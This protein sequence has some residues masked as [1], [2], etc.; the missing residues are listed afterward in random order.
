MHHD[1]HPGGAPFDLPPGELFR[2]VD[3]RIV[4]TVEWLAHRRNPTVRQVEALACLLADAIPSQRS[5]NFELAVDQAVASQSMDHL[6]HLLPQLPSAIR[7]A[8]MNRLELLV[9][10]LRLYGR[11]LRSVLSRGNG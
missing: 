1:S 8:P 4:S 11:I 7:P 6:L 5:T 9:V 3:G 10:A 2:S